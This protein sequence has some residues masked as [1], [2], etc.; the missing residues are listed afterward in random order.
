MSD[1]ALAEHDLVL[2]G[3]TDDVMVT[4]PLLKKRWR[5]SSMWLHRFLKRPDCPL[6]PPFYIG[7]HRHWWMSWVV[8]AERQF[9]AGD[10][11]SESARLRSRFT[12]RN[13]KA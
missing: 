2:D 1:Q 8:A 4:A 7:G 5:K 3:G 13:D 6:H 9:A 10:A 11:A 12:A